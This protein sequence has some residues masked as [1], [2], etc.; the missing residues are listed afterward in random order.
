MKDETTSKGDL[1]NRSPKDYPTAV[2]AMDL[3]EDPSKVNNYPGRYLIIWDTDM[4]Q[5]TKAGRLNQAI[6]YLADRGWRVINLSTYTVLGN[7]HLFALMEKLP[8]DSATQ[9]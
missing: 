3:L 8:A 4:G 6:C 7:G 1:L 5:K 2:C 9:I